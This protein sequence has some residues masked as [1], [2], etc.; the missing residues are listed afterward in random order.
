MVECLFSSA[1]Y[2][3]EFVTNLLYVL[4]H[5]RIKLNKGPNGKFGFNIINISRG[6]IV[7]DITKGGGAENSELL[8][9][10]QVLAINLETSR[11][12]NDLIQIVVASNSTLDLDVYRQGNIYFKLNSIQPNIGLFYIYRYN[13]K[14]G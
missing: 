11:N 1:I 7:S 2:N 8:I 13:H 9:G 14:I 4:G 3:S 5:R 12:K 10:D 6:I